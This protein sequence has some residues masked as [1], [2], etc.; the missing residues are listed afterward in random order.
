MYTVL[1]SVLLTLGL[2]SGVSNGAN[3]KN[4]HIGAVLSSNDQI[5][6][7]LKARANN[8]EMVFLTFDLILGDRKHK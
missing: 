3:P 4:Y 2:L 8:F 1:L 5:N 7:F 6:E